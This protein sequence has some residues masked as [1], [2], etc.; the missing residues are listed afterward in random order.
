MTRAQAEALLNELG[1]AIV[2]AEWGCPPP[3][4]KAD[5]Y[6]RLRQAREAIINALVPVAPFKLDSPFGKEDNGNE[7]YIKSRCN[8]HEAVPVEPFK[9]TM[10]GRIAHSSRGCYEVP[11]L[12]QDREDDR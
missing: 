3:S 6:E 12:T 4:V 9:L 1:A 11:P 7:E 2:S 8:C 10:R 5:R